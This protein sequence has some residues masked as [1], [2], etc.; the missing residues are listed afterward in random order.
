MEYYL[1]KKYFN[2]ELYLKQLNKWIKKLN[3]PNN[4]D[5]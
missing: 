5:I 3:K 1:K 2:P 4:V